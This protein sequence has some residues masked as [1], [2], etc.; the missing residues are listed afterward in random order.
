M[1]PVLHLPMRG[2]VTAPSLGGVN[3]SRLAD[4]FGNKGPQTRYFGCVQSIEVAGM[5]AA[6]KDVVDVLVV[7]HSEGLHG[8]FDGGWLFEGGCSRARLREDWWCVTLQS[9]WVQG[10][11]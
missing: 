3:L 6:L 10:H 8:L 7:F 9:V 4:V 1:R 2:S 11:T 5:S